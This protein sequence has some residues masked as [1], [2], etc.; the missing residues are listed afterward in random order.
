[1][2]RVIYG[3]GVTEFIGSIGGATFQNNTSGS[4]VRQRPALRQRR[5]TL[6]SAQINNFVQWS[7]YFRDLS[8]TDKAVWQSYSDDYSFTDFW[9][10]PKNLTA[11]QWFLV[12]N[13]AYFALNSGLSDTPL[14][15]ATPVESAQFTVDYNPSDIT[16]TTATTFS[17]SAD[18]LRVYFSVPTPQ[19]LPIKRKLLKVGAGY[20]LGNTGSYD[21]TSMWETATGLNYVNDVYN[22]GL[23]I[24]VGLTNIY[25]NFYIP[26][27]LVFGT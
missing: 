9:G 16:L 5:T 21:M 3:G 14:G 24:Q 8:P 1:M 22:K 26:S 20:I 25:T 10:R 15:Y 4:I 2:A 18:V 23:K 17:T 13:G 7:Q 6:Q 19:Q 27:P 12:L 11:L